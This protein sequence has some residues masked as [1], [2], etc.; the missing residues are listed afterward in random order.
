MRRFGSIGSNWC[1]RGGWCHSWSPTTVE[2]AGSQAVQRS[3]S[4]HPQVSPM[5]VPRMT[6]QAMSPEHPQTRQIRV[7]PKSMPR[8]TASSSPWPSSSASASM[9]SRLIQSVGSIGSGGRTSSPGAIVRGLN[10]VGFVGAIGTGR[11][12]SDPPASQ[13]SSIG[14][15]P[16]CC[17]AAFRLPQRHS[18]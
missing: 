8:S 16:P 14:L 18:K 5:N 13:C 9:R 3:G 12:R 7:D 11:S 2:Q 6:T 17:A 15:K 10:S 4:L 1:C